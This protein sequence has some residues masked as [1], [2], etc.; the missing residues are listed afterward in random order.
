[1]QSEDVWDGEDGRGARP[2]AA[3][4]RANAASSDRVVSLRR[5]PAAEPVRGR[6]HMSPADILASLTR[7]IA[8]MAVV[9]LVIAGLGLVVAMRLPKDYT[10]NASLL[11]QLN[12]DYVYNPLAGDAARGAIAT[13]DQM[14]QAETE[15][16]NSTE[17]KKRVIAKLGYRTLLPKSPALWHPVSDVQKAAADQAALRVLTSGLSTATA[18]TDSVV[19]LSFKFNDGEDAAL[20][21]NTLIDE[22][23]A[24][25]QSVFSDATGPLLEAQK[26]H[27]DDQLAN[28]DAAYQQFLDRNGVGDF[29]AAKATYSKVYDQVQTDL[30]TAR[31]ALAQDR[32]KLGDVE[33][34]LKTLSPEM[35]VERDLDLSIPAKILSLQQDRQDKLSRYLPDSQPIKDLDAQIASL[36]ALVSS[37]KGVG[38]KDHK[39]GI[40][41]VYQ[42]LLQQK[43]DLQSDMAAQQGRIGQLE[44]QSGQVIAKEQQLQGA[45]A[46]YN[47]LAAER[48]TLQ[49]NIKTFTQ[50]IQEN[51][52]TRR[53][54]QGD[55]AVRVVERATPPDKAKS[56]KSVV[57]ILALLLAAVTALAVGVLRVL[58]RKGFASA[59]MASKALDLPVLAQAGKKAA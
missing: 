59:G 25:R 15:I 9:F 19:R 7:E 6:L 12:K 50:R 22:Y 42:S 33:V 54:T 49:N 53:M 35:S 27:F 21:L 38:E 4:A 39:L 11:M 14:V 34:N 57:M 1:M 24:Y 45:D 23:Q 43:L 40:N 47:A 13:V 48:D 20:I 46:E 52:A 32:A 5:D 10:A 29:D 36:Q 16:L 2:R 41:T 28:A 3:K 26:A 31:A 30:Y 18:P 8:L 17:L 55:D 37:G 58:T 56:L 44:A 51:D